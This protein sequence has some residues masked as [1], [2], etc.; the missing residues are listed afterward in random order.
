MNTLC[1]IFCIMTFCCIADIRLVDGLNQY[2]GRVELY[3]NG[4]WGSICN[5]EFDR[6]DG[7]VVC[8]HLGY[9]TFSSMAN[10]GEGTQPIVFSDVHCSGIE[11]NIFDCSISEPS[12]SDCQPGEEV[13]VICNPL[14]EFKNTTVV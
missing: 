8:N 12:D 13:G 2:E 11:E 1:N 5:Y 14:G 4:Q 7:N 10:F 6:R 9:A 3:R